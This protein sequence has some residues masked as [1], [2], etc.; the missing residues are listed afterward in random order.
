MKYRA[1]RKKINDEDFKI[2]RHVVDTGYIFHD[3]MLKQL[4]LEYADDDTTVMLISDHGFHPDH[5]RPEVIPNEPAGPAKEHRDYGIF[6]ATGPNIR[7]GHSIQGANLLDIAPTVLTCYGLRPARTWTTG[8]S[9]TSSPNA[10]H[11]RPSR[12]GNSSRR[13]R[14]ASRRLRRSPRRNRRRP[15]SSSWPSG[16]SIA[17]RTTRTPPSPTANANSNTTS[18]GPTWTPISTARRPRGCSSSTAPT[19][20]SSDSASSWPPAFGPSTTTT[21]SSRCCDMADRWRKYATLA[22]E[23]SA[24]I[25][26]LKAER[27]APMEALKKVEDEITDP[28]I[29]KMARVDPEESGS[30]QGSRTTHASQDPGGSRR[31]TLDRWTS[32]PR[33]R[34]LES[35]ISKTALALINR[36]RA[37]HGGDPT[38]HV[39]RGN[40]LISLGRLEEAETSL[41]AGLEI[42]GLNPKFDG[43]GPLLRGDG[44]T[45]RSG[46]DA[47]GKAIDLQHQFPLA[48][49]FRGLAH[50]GLGE[51]EPAVAS[52]NEAIRQN[53]NFEEGTPPSRTSTRPPRRRHARRRASGGGR[54][55]RRGESTRVRGLGPDRVRDEVHRRTREAPSD[56][57]GG[58]FQP[59]LRAFPSN[60]T[61]CRGRSKR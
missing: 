24:K 42:D 37:T 29:D 43:T 10:R 46:P 4:L 9:R 26:A 2:Y 32:W 12:A 58:D 35:V 57:R 23:E 21:I 30:L 15:S 1:Q 41:K 11:S 18:P 27:L 51:F 19:P 53:P 3:M 34:R 47:S 17:P 60:R 56:H 7:T 20:W 59:G 38:F 8:S 28:E 25:E 33:R 44:T 14:R 31:A 45:R 54:G 48:H 22:A 13:D 55:P 52:L 5:L 49:Y 39:H 6:V 50:R 61:G 36:T 40:V 16:T